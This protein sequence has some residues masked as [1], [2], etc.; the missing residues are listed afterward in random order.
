MKTTERDIVAKESYP[1]IGIPLLGAL[2]GYRMGW[3]ILTVGGAITAGCSAFFFRNP[4]R[5]PPDIEGAVV[6]PADGIVLPVKKVYE[7]FFFKKE[8]DRVSIFMSLFDVHINRSPVDGVVVGTHYNRGRFISAFKEKASLDNE[9]HAMLIET[10]SHRRLVLVQ[11]AG[12]V[13][14]RIVTYKHTS[15]ALRIGEIIGLIRFGSR[16]DVYV[17]GG[18]DVQVMEG[19]RVKAGETVI[20]VFR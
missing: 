5:S 14:R 18:V 1:F 17:E 4:K 20:G 6:S 7:R 12:F 3:K 2:L 16:L 11:I 19:E 15:D 13:A 9:Q 10:E 8:V